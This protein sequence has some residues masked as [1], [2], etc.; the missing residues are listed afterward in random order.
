ME[1]IILNRL[2][3]FLI[4]FNKTHLV[5]YFDFNMQRR[6]LNVGTMIELFRGDCEDDLLA[7]KKFENEMKDEDD[8]YILLAAEKLEKSN[9]TKSVLNRFMQN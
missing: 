1:N 6:R 4:H 9:E 7:A 3:L 2:I 5:V 8:I